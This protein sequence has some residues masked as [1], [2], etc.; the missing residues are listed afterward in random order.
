MKE[1]DINH[2]GRVDYDEVA[3]VVTKEMRESGYSF[4]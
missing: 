3:S 1:M 2:D 4:M